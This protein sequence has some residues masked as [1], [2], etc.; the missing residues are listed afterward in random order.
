MGHG[1]ELI[2]LVYLIL[3]EEKAELKMEI[4]R[5]RELICFTH[6][7]V[8]FSLARFDDVLLQ[9]AFLLIGGTRSSAGEQHLL[10][11]NLKAMRCTLHLPHIYKRMCEKAE[12]A[13]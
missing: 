2:R 8:F 3:F 10:R 9:K 12:S 1:F 11:A 6:S 13:E 4:E 5:M 7:L